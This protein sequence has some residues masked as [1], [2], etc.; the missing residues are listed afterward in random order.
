MAVRRASCG[1]CEHVE[2]PTM[3]AMTV[4]PCYPTNVGGEQGLS[5]RDRVAAWRKYITP[6]V[7][8]CLIACRVVLVGGQRLRCYA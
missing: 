7:A 3:I 6:L 2:R 5:Y 1:G 4:F 8:V